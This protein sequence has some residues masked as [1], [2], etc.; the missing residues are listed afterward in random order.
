MFLIN[1]LTIKNRFLSNLPAKITLYKRMNIKSKLLRITE[2][3]WSWPSPDSR[4][5]YQSTS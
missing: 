1:E 2:C 4:T 5:I 3:P